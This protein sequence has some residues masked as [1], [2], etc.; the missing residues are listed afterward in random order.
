MAISVC[1]VGASGLVGRELVAQ[2]CDDPRV[3]AI[4]LMLRRVLNTFG[5]NPK[6]SQ[7]VIDFEQI[8]AVEWPACD[9]ICCC[10]GTTIKVAG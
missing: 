6:L 7:H 4:S 3:T 10:L 1:V 8:A 9:V 5:T 2:L